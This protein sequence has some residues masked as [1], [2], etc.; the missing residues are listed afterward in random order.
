[1]KKEALV[2][3]YMAVNA[4]NA[5]ETV[6]KSFAAYLQKVALLGTFGPFENIWHRLGNIWHR[7]GNI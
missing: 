3:F 6:R 5:I 1:V 2:L 4:I 7:L